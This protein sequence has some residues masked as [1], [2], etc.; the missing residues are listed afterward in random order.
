MAYKVKIILKYKLI[1]N[2]YK[3][4][5]FPY[6]IKP[7]LGPFYAPCKCVLFNIFFWLNKVLKEYNSSASLLSELEPK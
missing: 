5:E 6:S 3:C 1:I 2:V 7:F 4:H